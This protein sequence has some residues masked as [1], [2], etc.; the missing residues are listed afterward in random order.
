MCIRA[1]KGLR[2]GDFA[3]EHFYRTFSFLGNVR[4]SLEHD[5]LWN[6]RNLFNC[7]LGL[8]FID[9]ARLFVHIQ[10]DTPLR[11]K[12]YSPDRRGD[13]PQYMLCV[14]VD[15]EGSPMSWEV[16]PENTAD[17]KALARMVKTLR[18]RFRIGN[19]CL[20]PDRA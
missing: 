7:Q 10:P 14:G 9:M 20:V 18:K 8:V 13:M 6:D 4:H 1:V 16:L 11:E 12:G 2:L 5:L 17:K 3:V 15:R 19:G